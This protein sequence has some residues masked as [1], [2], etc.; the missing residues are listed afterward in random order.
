MDAV[1]REVLL[2][3][4]EECAEPLTAL[5]DV[6]EAMEQSTADPSTLEAATEIASRLREVAVMMEVDPL[7]LVTS[8]LEQDFRAAVHQTVVIPALELDRPPAHLVL[9]SLLAA[10]EAV[11]SHLAEG[12]TDC[13]ELLQDAF[14]LHRRFQGLAQFEGDLAQGLTPPANATASSIV[15]QSST[16]WME[17][18]AE[19]GEAVASP[20][21]SE[22]PRGKSEEAASDLVPRES[23]DLD[24]FS[25]DELFRSEAELYLYEALR[26]LAAARNQQP[27]PDLL[28]ECRRLAHTVKGMAGV[29]GRDQIASKAHAIEQ[30]LDCVL[31]GEERW[32]DDDLVTLVDGIT[33]L[34]DLVQEQA[35][36]PGDAPSDLE[37]RAASR[38]SPVVEADATLAERPRPR[39]ETHPIRSEP[40]QSAALA[41]SSAPAVQS[42]PAPRPPFDLGDFAKI[43]PELLEVFSEEA[44]EHLV[45]LKELLVKIESNLHDQP[46]IAEMRRVAHTLKGAAGAVK[47]H[48]VA[49]VAKWIENRLDHL[50][51]TRGT[52][53]DRD[54]RWLRSTIGQVETLVSGEFDRRKVQEELESLGAEF[55]ALQAEAAAAEELMDAGELARASHHDRESFAAQ[56]SATR[57]R[58]E[59][60]PSDYGDLRSIPEELHEVFIAEADEHLRNLDSALNR[61]LLNPADKAAILDAQRGAHTLKGAAGALKL[62]DL[63]GLAHRMEDL[64]EAIVARPELG[65][66]S[67]VELLLA[68]TDCLAEKI[69]HP[70]EA[71]SVDLQGHELESLLLTALHPPTATTAT[72][73]TTVSPA[74][75]QTEEE[76]IDDLE[77]LS[78]RLLE[79]FTS[80]AEEQL[81]LTYNALTTLES[82]PRDRDSLREYKRRLTKLKGT[83]KAVKLGGMTRLVSLM[84]LLAETLFE[85]G[86]GMS[87]DHHRLLTSGNDILVDLALGHSD[88]S[89]ITR[90]VSALRV[91]L[92]E[93][94]EEL[95][96][97]PSAED[98]PATAAR[99]ATLVNRSKSDQVAIAIEPSRGSPSVP[100]AG[101]Q[102]VEADAP[103]TAASTPSDSLAFP[104]AAAKRRGAVKPQPARQ[105]SA[106]LRVPIERLDELVRLASEL[107]I[108]RT[109]FEQRK[110]ELVRSVGEIRASIER[111]RVISTE[112]ET[113]FEATA[114]RGNRLTRS[115]EPTVDRFQFRA[116]ADNSR[117]E[118]DELEFDRY[119]R[120]HLLSRSLAE[121][122]SDINTISNEVSTLIGDFDTLI[123]R[124]GRLT[125]DIQDKLMWV[126]MV[127]LSSM[128]TQL[129][130]TVRS[131]A[132]Q[133]GRQVDLVIEGQHTEL[134]KT[135]L[136]EMSEPFLHLLRNAVDHGIEPAAVRLAR[137]KPERGTI[138]I[139]AFYLGTQ[140]VIEIGDD[141][142]GIDV[143]AIRSV[144]LSQN[145]ISSQEVERTAPEDLLHLIFAP[146]FTTTK[147]LSEISGRGVGMDIVKSKIHK[148]KGTIEVHST[149]GSGTTFTIRLPMTVAITRALLVKVSQV[150]YAIP[151]QTIAQI[152]R[153]EASKI[154]MVGAQRMVRVG[155]N[156]Y[157]LIHLADLVN[158]RCASEDGQGLVSILLVNLGTRQVA[159]SIDQVISNREIV[160]KTLGT[161][162]RRVMGVIGATL[163]GDG[164]VVPIL[165]PIE[166]IDVPERGEGRRLKV[167]PSR[168]AASAAGTSSWSN[169]AST[170]TAA[171]GRETPEATTILIVDDSVSVRRVLANL[172]KNSGW[173]PITAKDGIDA[174]ETLQTLKRPPDAI[175]LDIEMP[176]MDGYELLSQIRSQDSTLATPVVML[177]SRAGQKHRSKAMDLGASEYVVKPYQDDVL[178]TLLGDLLRKSRDYAFA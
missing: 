44:N 15:E 103:S 76:W 119:T 14:A 11:V 141:G 165:N 68:A 146:G 143:N 127:P 79:I 166:M 175:L 101:H 133:L 149:P 98:F 123:N 177:T 169:S 6:I 39:P 111:M 55:D 67:N 93:A 56:S 112:L 168:Q 71:S 84:E 3:F 28:N 90:V 121:A 162:L 147:Q 157:P 12:G 96:V 132:S 73:P 131:V 82:E 43:D 41:H 110:N 31:T 176:R 138:Q 109:S 75:R 113:S 48:G 62:V 10:L 172:I 1:N 161:H 32:R 129:S 7:I 21:P 160:V 170:P 29:S 125:R 174:M 95:G 117:D 65:T 89:E 16:P 22:D 145:L 153:V 105:T 69:N 158:L 34:L 45:L 4:L 50:K 99:P 92:R 140:V 144:A 51:Q 26:Q 33:Q 94:L 128:A 104:A 88:R 97:T 122:T 13:H 60:G 53:Q 61:L 134:D 100:G 66:T 18:E 81:R 120:F 17:L 118:F 25:D 38:P 124:Q 5:G 159:L 49:Q 78:P 171:G 87:M 9:R 136:E 77:S 135:V 23:Q 156:L 40:A 36:L 64:L 173:H 107:V 57:S 8:A 58:T 102:A 74:T 52:P 85:R 155:A 46:S 163:L 106:S 42:M 126:R 108:N 167:S 130:R 178:V 91:K 59:S 30:Q 152:K 63:T 114:L 139:R 37:E 116:G 86:E 54:L 115:M 70:G 35:D 142:Q 83:T 72:P 20:F 164:T 19:I 151:V 80:E 137:G 154:E 2:G 27:K 24:F 150:I 47:L 148:L